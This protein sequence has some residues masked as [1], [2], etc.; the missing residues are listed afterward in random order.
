MRFVVTELNHRTREAQEIAVIEAP[1]ASD[2][3]DLGSLDLPP[4]AV[5]CPIDND[6]DGRAFI[7]DPEDRDHR[8]VADPVEN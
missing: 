5:G 8:I 4:W 1:S 7:T 6:G 2:A 3:L